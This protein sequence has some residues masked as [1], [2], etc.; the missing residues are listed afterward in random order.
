MNITKVKTSMKPAQVKSYAMDGETTLDTLS[1]LGITL[2]HQGVEAWKGIAMDADPALITSASVATPIQFL[3]HFIA[4]PVYTLT[5]KRKIDDILGRDIA[6]RAIDEEIVLRAIELT[7]QAR[8]YTDKANPPMAS[9]NQNFERRTVCRFEVG[10]EVGTLEEERAAAMMINAGAEKRAAVA[11]AHA[12]ILNKVG[13]YGYNDGSNRTYGL[14]NDPN[15]P[16]YGTV[17][18]NAGATATTWASKTFAEI[19]KDIKTAVAALIVRSGSNFDPQNSPFVMA[20]ASDAFT[21][22]A[23]TTDFGIS[24][25]DWIK[26]VYPSCR[27]EIVP[28][29]VAATSGSS[30]FY[31]IAEELEGRKVANQYVQDVFRLLGVERKIKGFKEDSLCA[32]AG[33]LVS[34]PIGIVRYKGI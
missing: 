4:E 29:F 23:T 32:T 22:L 10:F 11:R 33:V 27:I 30:V 21:Y 31:L 14:L 2:G 3:Q 20:V 8:Q 12:I 17:A 16:N 18:L 28:E 9:F 1:G 5:Q 26:K 6:G 24:V 19:Q 15:L 25:A 7:G 34:Q 13:F